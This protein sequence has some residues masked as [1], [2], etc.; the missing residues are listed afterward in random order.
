MDRRMWDLAFQRLSRDFRVIRYDL[1]GAGRSQ[2]NHTE[3]YSPAED[4]SG[5]LK[6]LGEGRV[7]VIGLSR[8]GAIALDF[9]LR[10]PEQTTSL[11]V[12]E[13]A[14]PG[15]RFVSST[16]AG[17]RPDSVPRSPPPSMADIADT[18]KEDVSRAVEMLLL[19]PPFD[20]LRL[21]PK[22]LAAVRTL[23][24][25]N[26]HLLKGGDGEVFLTEPRIADR[27]GS[28]RVPVLAISGEEAELSYPGQV[29]AALRRGIPGAETATISGAG[30]FSNIEKP[31]EFFRVVHAFLRRHSAK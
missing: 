20:R 13:P 22:E 6:V 21:M 28:I 5:L 4:L 17:V 10:F 15:F 2:R 26:A 3:P 18:A 12:A 23:M 7:H 31:E 27:L 1:R 19:H 14:L 16:A 30:H 24:R 25:E 29:Q 9:A 11:I 8:G